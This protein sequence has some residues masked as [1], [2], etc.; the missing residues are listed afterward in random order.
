MSGGANLTTSASLTDSGTI[1][2]GGGST[3]TV[4]GGYAQTSGGT[5]GVTLASA[6]SSTYT[7][8]S[9][10]SRAGTFA[11]VNTTNAVKGAATPQVSYTTTGVMITEV[12]GS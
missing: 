6:S 10:A 5:L 11:T 1:A 7:A 12:P 3:L 8:L 2:V 4:G 9:S